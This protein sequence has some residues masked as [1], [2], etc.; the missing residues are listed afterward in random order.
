MKYAIVES[1]GKQYKAVPGDTIR[2]DRLPKNEIGDEIT[3]EQVLFI[4]D[5]EEFHIGTPLVKGAQV[6]ATVADHIKGKKIVVFKYKP[7]NRYRVKKGHRQRYTLLKIDNIM[8][9]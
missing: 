8:M 3:L 7:A 1:G 9:E 2:V 6:Q 5:D 4:A